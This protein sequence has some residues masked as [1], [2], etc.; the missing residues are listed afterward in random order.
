M[1][2]DKKIHVGIYVLVS[3]LHKNLFS[4]IRFAL[5]A[6][7][8][9]FFW[10]SAMSNQFKPKPIFKK[11]VWINKSF[12]LTFSEIHRGAQQVTESLPG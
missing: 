1:C 9:Y 8:M 5:G 4:N 3:L 11:E 2:I 7:G 10:A 12:S 6:G